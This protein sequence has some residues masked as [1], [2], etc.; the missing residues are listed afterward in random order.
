M[1]KIGMLTLAVVL[2]M[3]LGASVVN[4]QLGQ[5]D[6]ASFRV[7]N[8]ST[9][10]AHVQ[11]TFYDEAG[12]AY[13]PTTLNMGKPNPFDLPAGTSFEVYL[14]GIPSGLPNGR[15]SVVISSDQPVVATAN[16]VGADGTTTYYNGAYSG[17]SAGATTYYLPAVYHNYYGW[18]DIISVQNVGSAATDIKVEY[19]QGDTKV[20]EHTKSALAAGASVHFDLKTSVP[21]GMP[22]SFGGSAVVTSTSQPIVV[23][24]NQRATGGFTQSYNGFASGANTIY[25]P[26]L[27]ST[28]YTWNSSLFVQ[29]VGAANTDVH[30]VY[31]DGKTRDVTLAPKQSVQ[32]EEWDGKHAPGI[33]VG[34]TITTTGQPVVAVANAANPARQAQTY[35]AFITGGTKVVLPTIMKNYWGW[36]TS[37]TVMNIGTANATVTVT[38]APDS[39]H[40]FGG[41]NYNITVNAGSSHQIY[42]PGDSNVTV[43]NYGGSVTLSTSTPG[44]LLIATCDETYGAGQ[45][46]G[47]GD[48]SMSYNGFAQ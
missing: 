5:T 11:I 39:E 45:A 34:A 47:T 23:V 40:G 3:T 7:M 38:Y 1:K 24:N 20:A 31:T 2:A 13:T 15:Y 27:Y 17:V 43:A 19:Y 4:A 21:P 46:A 6:N 22:P 29:N 36:D 35:S 9:S 26:A 14:P 33:S 42:V 18:N 32:W 28:F 10:T 12:T 44:A 37:F 48:W 16:L 30:V 25:V 41:A 8:L